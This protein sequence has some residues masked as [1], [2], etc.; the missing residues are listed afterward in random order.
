M[1]V[2]GAG[3]RD[4]ARVADVHGHHPQLVPLQSPLQIQLL[5]VPATQG[6]EKARW[7]QLGG[8]NIPSLTQNKQS[9]FLPEGLNTDSL[10]LKS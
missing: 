2:Q 6:K 4:G 1:G 9:M 8:L 3:G 5:I 10:Y 7:E